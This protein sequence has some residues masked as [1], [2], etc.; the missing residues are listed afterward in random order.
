MENRIHLTI[1]DGIADVRLNHA[2]KMNALNP[3][4]FLA[5]AELGVP[6]IVRATVRYPI[7]TIFCRRQASWSRPT[8][9][10]SAWVRE[11]A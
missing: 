3:A 10:T 2:A 1:A 8:D 7:S 9:R 4:M 5:I 11:C 6:C